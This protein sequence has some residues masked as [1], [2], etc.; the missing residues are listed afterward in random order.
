MI[1]KLPLPEKPIQWYDNNGN[2]CRLI[3]SPLCDDDFAV[4]ILSNNS[5]YIR[6][7]SK[8]EAA[9][10]VKCYWLN[11]AS[12]IVEEVGYA[13]ACSRTDYNEIHQNIERCDNF[14]DF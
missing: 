5:N 9:C 1:N 13:L 8:F 2:L 3:P 6:G 10:I 11:K 12:K 14:L 7:F 4:E